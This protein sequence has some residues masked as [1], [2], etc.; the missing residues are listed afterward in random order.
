MQ[1]EHLYTKVI[2]EISMH[3]FIPGLWAKSFAETGGDEQA[4]KAMYL[5]L[6]ADQ[7]L[8]LEE[9]ELITAEK[10]STAAKQAE[11]LLSNQSRKEK[12]IQFREEYLS[13]PPEKISKL[14]STTISL[15]AIIL[16]AI[17]IWH[18]ASLNY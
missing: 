16:L 3:G 10:A 8:I 12:A 17:I 1:N 13:R 5:R 15:A 6:R 11:N 14:Q 2:N 7:I 9:A 18:T 4:A